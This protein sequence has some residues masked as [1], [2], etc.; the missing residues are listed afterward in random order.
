MTKYLLANW[1]SHK[2]L[3]QAESWL[4][5]FSRL[6]RPT[7]G[8]KVII[9]PAMVHL[10]PLR[11]L[12]NNPAMP[13]LA[14]ASQDLSPFPL[15]SYTGAVAAEMVRGLVD[16]A[17]LGHSERR[18]Y[19]HETNQDVANKVSEARAAAI[20]PIVCLDRPYARAQL[21][22]LDEADLK[23]LLIGYGP[24]EA[25]GV[26]IPPSPEKVGKV[27]A[28]LQAMAPDAAIL[29]GG[30]I[31]AEN[32]ADYLGLAGVAGLMVGTASLAAEEFARIC[33]IAARASA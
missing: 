5:E 19:F 11:Q 17:I 16:F 24:V 21:A 32:A 23:G 6:Y 12:L 27:I 10:A 26:D 18:R 33:A 2:S 30:S 14:L 31:T 3:A 28:E 7:E 22:A 8:L 25:I 9:A 13:E 4:H 15:G 29:Y 1:K 20:Q